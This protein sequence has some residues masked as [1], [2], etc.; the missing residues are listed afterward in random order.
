VRLFESEHPEQVA[1]MVLVDA[2]VDPVRSRALV[3]QDEL[4]KFA[5]MFERAGEGLDFE[6]FAAGAAEAR[7]SSRSL[8]A[9]PLVVLT[10]SIEDSPP[11]ATLEQNAEMRRTW[12]ELQAELPKLSSNAIQVTVPGARH[13]IQLDAPHVVAAAIV[14]VVRAVREHRPL[15]AGTLRRLGE[16]G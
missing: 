14:E 15:N 12:R 13:Y 4:R 6:T 2:T 16:A 9:K 5:H 10:R 11:W 1:G 3:P 7:A 8:G